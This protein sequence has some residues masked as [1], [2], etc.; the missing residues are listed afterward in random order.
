VLAQLQLGKVQ[1]LA[2]QEYPAASLLDNGRVIPPSCASTEAVSK[3]ESNQADLMA[4]R[5]LLQYRAVNRKVWAEEW[6][7]LAEG[8]R[9][10]GRSEQA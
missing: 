8:R 2:L 7:A 9:P 5:I 10:R 1:L 4:S 6:L 3:A